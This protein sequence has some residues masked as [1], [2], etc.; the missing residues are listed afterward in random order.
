MCVGADA[1]VVTLVDKLSAANSSLG[2]R[3]LAAELFARNSRLANNAFLN[4]LHRGLRG[5]RCQFIIS[6]L[7][8]NSMIRLILI[9]THRILQLIQHILTFLITLLTSSPAIV[10]R[11]VTTSAD[12][13]DRVFCAIEVEL[14]RLAFL[15]P[16][17]TLE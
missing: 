14:G 9:A 16:M 5:L 11:T 10:V 8:H 17:T 2:N 3:A 1:T 7:L 6:I 12:C 13:S 15:Y 4:Y